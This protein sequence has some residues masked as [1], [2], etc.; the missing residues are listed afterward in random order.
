[1]G[2][3]VS[4]T[5]VR[6][7]EAQC[8]LGVTLG[9]IAPD[10]GRCI[11]HYVCDVDRGASGGRKR[12]KTKQGVY[13]LKDPEKQ[14]QASPNMDEATC[15]EMLQDLWETGYYATLDGLHH[16]GE[17]LRE[18]LRV[19]LSDVSPSHRRRSRIFWGFCGVLV[20]VFGVCLF[21]LFCLLPTIS[22]SI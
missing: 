8:L 22:R 11:M 7:T 21:G 18:A 20:W 14:E 9:W 12:W 19:R 5:T 1:M 2:G 13:Q 3:P 4:L 17:L 6:T 15:A 16:W 10:F